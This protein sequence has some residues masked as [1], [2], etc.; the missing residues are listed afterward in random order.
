MAGKPTIRLTD[1]QQKQIKDA[2]GQTITE[3][4]FDAAATSNLTDQ[5]LD[6]VAGSVRSFRVAGTDILPELS[7]PATCGT[8]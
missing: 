7:S 3:L 1:D 2:M 5:D 6:Q 8:G 4:N